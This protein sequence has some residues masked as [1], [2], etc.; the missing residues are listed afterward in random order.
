MMAS[1]RRRVAL[2][3]LTLLLT[4]SAAIGM[5]G[6]LD[7]TRWQITLV[8]E[9]DA[10]GKGA[11]AIEDKVSF[12]DGKFSSAF[13]LARGFKP[14]KYKGETEINEAEFELEQTSKAEGVINWLGEIRRD[15]ISGRLQW[16]KKDGTTWWY[17]FHGKKD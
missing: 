5:A 4:L 1:R 16:Q 13:F 17:D 9:Q 7:G 6:F 12:A 14:A 15:E 2:L 10:A 11:K 3:E 8:P